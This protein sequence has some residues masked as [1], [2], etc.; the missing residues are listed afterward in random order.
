MRECPP[1]KAALRVS[2]IKLMKAI[3]VW[4][5]EERPVRRVLLRHPIGCTATKK[6]Q[7]KE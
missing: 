1:S 6:E 7:H 2:E 5:V 3:R 4:T